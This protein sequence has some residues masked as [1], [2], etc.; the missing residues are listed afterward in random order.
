MNDL[1]AKER[2]ALRHIRNSIVLRVR[3]DSMNM[4]GINDGDFVLVRQQS[5]ADPGQH[6]VVLIDDEATLKSYHPSREVTVL[7]PHST[8]HVHQP[9]IVD[10]DFEIQGVVV[11]AI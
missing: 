10:R 7:K 4:A 9:I 8:N 2:Q 1:T 11:K 3:G 6:V 5:T